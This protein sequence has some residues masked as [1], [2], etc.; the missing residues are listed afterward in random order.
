MRA[1]AY[2][3][4]NGAVEHAV[5]LYFESGDF[6]QAAH[7]AERNAQ[8]MFYQGRYDTLRDWERL[9]SNTDE[10][11]PYVNL[12]L[13]KVYTDQGDLGAARNF[14]LVTESRSSDDTSSSLRANIENQKA[15]IALKDREY[16]QARLHAETADRISRDRR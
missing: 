15:L 8:Q 2:L 16:E 11:V 3:E 5:N 1:A 12:Y 9:F 4:E 6:R 14:L 13:S 10:A 7:L